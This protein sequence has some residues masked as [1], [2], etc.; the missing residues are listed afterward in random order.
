MSAIRTAI[1]TQLAGTSAVTA[2]LSS[3]TAIYHRVAPADAQAPFVIFTK[4]AGTP[5]WAMAG[6][7]LDTDLWLIKG[8]C[9]GGSSSA[10][11]SIAAAVDDAINDAL[12]S[13]TGRNLL[14]LRRESDVDYGE[15]DGGEQWHHVGALYRLTTE[16]T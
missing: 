16:Q 13:I 3:P 14:F 8:V 7:P 6:D 15:A 10:A 9:T 12:L 1:Y 4:Q 5:R 2:L 11:E